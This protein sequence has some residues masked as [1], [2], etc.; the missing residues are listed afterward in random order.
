MAYYRRSSPPESAGQLPAGMTVGEP[1]FVA[2][3]DRPPPER[4]ALDRLFL[5]D[6]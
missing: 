4:D 1:E 2:D 3:A 6:A 5:G